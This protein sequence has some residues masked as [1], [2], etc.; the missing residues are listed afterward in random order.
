MADEL[1]LQPLE[2]LI[3]AGPTITTTAPTAPTTTTTA[4]TTTPPPPPAPPL[5]QPTAPPSL[6]NPGP[7][8]APKRQRRPSVR[9]GE[10]GDQPAATLS[11]DSPVRRAKH[12]WRFTKDSASAPPPPSK[13]SV[14]AR[15]LTNLNLV[16]GADSQEI[17]GPDERNP[18]GEGPNLEY[19]NRRAKAKRAAAVKRARSNWAASNSRVDDGA[20]GDSRDDLD[21]GFRDFD[22]ELDSPVRDQSPAQSLDNADLNINLDLWR[23]GGSGPR[24]RENEVAEAEAEAELSSSGVRSWLIELGL[25]RYAPVFEI[26]EVDDQVLP[27]LTLEDL[28]DMGINAVGSRRKMYTAIQKL[29]KGFS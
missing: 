13:S 7:S 23:N 18:S 8:L 20:E 3:T 28:K 26:H 21:E 9:L 17:A 27:M 6:Y 14:K 5:P 2:P 29:R 1:V 15:S 12:P 19:G 25:S 24:P 11:Y 10:I 4:P 16:N 22:P